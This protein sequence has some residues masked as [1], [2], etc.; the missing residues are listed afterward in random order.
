MGHMVFSWCKIPER[1][2]HMGHIASQSTWTPYGIGHMGLL[3]A[4]LFL[5]N[6]SYVVL[7]VRQALRRSPLDTLTMHVLAIR[8]RNDS[9]F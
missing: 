5:W 1:D 6:W 3:I 4:Q 9:I 2:G 7:V 8:L